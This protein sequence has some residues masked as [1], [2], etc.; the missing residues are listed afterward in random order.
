[1]NSE[2]P[3]AINA[4]SRA[5]CEIEIRHAGW[6]CIQERLW[7]PFTAGTGWAIDVK[8]PNKT[9]RINDEKTLR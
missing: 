3:S 5:Q 8:E 1:M 4:V 6:I 7:N 9:G 2:P